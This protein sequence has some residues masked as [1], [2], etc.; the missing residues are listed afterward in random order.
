MLAAALEVNYW[1]YEKATYLPADDRTIAPLGICRRT[2]ERCG[3]ESTLLTAALRAVS[4][5]ARQCYA[6]FWAHCDDN[7][8]WVEFWAE[9]QWHYM[10]ACEP[11]IVP[12]TGW[13]TSAASRAM[14]VR[15]F[16]PDFAEKSGLELVNTT[17]L[18]ADTAALRVRL[19]MAGKPCGGVRVRFQLV[20]DCQLQTLCEAET[21]RD[22][23]A[24]LETGLGSLVVSAF[25]CGRLVE[26]AVDVRDTREAALRWEEGFDPLREERMD[27]W[28][29]VPPKERIPE[30][31]AENMAHQAQL[32]HCEA[33]RSAYEDGFPREGGRW[34]RLVR[35]NHAEI[36]RFLDLPAYAREDKEL[37]LSTL[38]EKDLAD[39]SCETLE[40]F[41]SAALLWKEAWPA[42][43][44]RDQILAPRVEYEMLLPIRQE[45]AARLS[46][47]GL[48]S[49]QEVLAWME[50]HLRPIA[51][52]GPAGRRGSAA[53]YLRHGVCP[54]AEWNIMAVQLC[55]ALGIPARLCPA[56]GDFLAA[57]VSEPP[58]VR[59]TLR[60]EEPALRY[61]EHFTLA[62]WEGDAY[63]CLQLDGFSVSDRTA[64][65]LRPGAYSLITSRRQ[66]DG[67][68]SARAVR[69]L[70]T[71]DRSISLTLAPDRTV[72]KLR[73][74][75]LPAAEGLS[76]PQGKAALLLFLQPGAE[77]TEH[78]LQEILAL[79]EDYKRG[80]WP[81]RFLL[82]RPEERENDTLRR[83]LAALPESECSLYQNDWRFAVQRAMGLG[84]S[85]LPLAVV[86]DK[87]G[88]G[89]YASANYVIRSA[90]T[91]L[92]ILKM[93]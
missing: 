28:E 85:R 24:W 27:A 57:G 68:A 76:L 65:S 56:T 10:G 14:L 75:Q 7:H 37:L 22:G 49:G 36:A 63:R 3:E 71:E 38:A 34:L 40:S 78:L 72:E 81:L 70:L 2:R 83:V 77:P 73:S 8:A 55:R 66:I 69:F 21:D 92:R 80:A 61:K 52:Y 58:E 87:N 12:D 84:D 79:C 53:G 59:L 23:R 17:S 60:T 42:D 1:C 6:P 90:H 26:K 46:G 4:I 15:S 41:L 51:E 48:R 33:V 44:W 43:I 5:P 91:L 19:T 88:R 35:G 32:R 30:M 31:P 86:L 93:L 62:R 13:F 9:G 18:Y 39:V 89:V 11:E 16:A 54:K 45:L 82:S 50:T 20:N 67:T 25:F 47:E 64:L 29:L 74:V